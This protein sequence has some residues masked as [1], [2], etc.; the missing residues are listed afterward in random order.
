M[1]EKSE[2]GFSIQDLGSSMSSAVTAALSEYKFD[3]AMASIWD[4]IK[5]A[6][7]FVSEKRVWVKDKERVEAL[8]KL[9]GEIRQIAVDLAPFMPETAEKIDKQFRGEKIVKGESLFP[10]LT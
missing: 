6:D 4:K 8:T 9:V 7:Q 3:V 1:A 5:K 10:R 2:I